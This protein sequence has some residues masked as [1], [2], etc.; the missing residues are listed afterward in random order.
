MSKDDDALVLKGGEGQVLVDLTQH[1]DKAPTVTGE[2]D[3]LSTW[4]APK[5]AENGDFV[6]VD[7]DG[8]EILDEKT[9]KPVTVDADGD[10]LPQKPPEGAEVK[11][12]PV[13]PIGGRY[14][15]SP[16]EIFDAQNVI[17]AETNRQIDEF[18]RFRDDVLAKEKWIFF[19]QTEEDAAPKKDGKPGTKDADPKRTETLIG[20]QNAL[21]QSVGGAIQLAG[22]LVAR[23]NDTAQIYAGADRRAWLDEED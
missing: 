18:E 15:V 13:P 5:A 20:T 4:I 17:L 19:A 6:L 8:K 11:D 2:N 12:P 14:S 7:A 16:G 21:L 22:E 3:K 9:G 10:P 23:L 1:W